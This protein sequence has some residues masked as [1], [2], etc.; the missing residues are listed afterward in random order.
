MEP[1][2]PKWKKFEKLAAEIQKELSPE[3]A[4]KHDEKIRGWDS[5]T[6]R[7]ID[8]VVRQNVGQY[9][10]L[11]VM[12]CKDEKTPLDV[13]A[14]GEFASVVSDVRAHKGALVS[15][16]G[17][18][19]AAINLAKQKGIDVFRLVDIENKDWKSYATLPAAAVFDALEGYQLKF[20]NNPNYPPERFAIPLKLLEDIPNTHLYKEDGTFINTI[21]N[22]IRTAW[23]SDKLPKKSGEYF[24]LKFVDEPVF[25]KDGEKLI[26]I[27]L[28]ANIVTR[29]QVFFGH[30][31]IKSMRGFHDVSTGGVY[32]RS[33]TTEWLN[34]ETIEKKWQ[35][36]ESLDQLAVKPLIIMHASNLYE[37][38]RPDS[39]SGLDRLT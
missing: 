38:L 2:D 26:P 14:V 25:I 21:I 18:T 4:V 37:P 32:T 22:A 19:E 13:N 9:P 7:Q 34:T 16:S 27:E 1:N 5:K 36:V 15:N 23:N 12:Q 24:D 28:T 35:K 29:Q 30:I 31:P 8:I 6:D 39:K 11:I 3:A 20:A 33:L 10:L 17:F